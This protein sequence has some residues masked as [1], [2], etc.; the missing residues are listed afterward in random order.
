MTLKRIT[1]EAICNLFPDGETVLI[2]PS[3]RIAQAQLEA[4]QKEYNELKEELEYL[5]E[6]YEVAIEVS[7][8]EHNQLRRDV[9]DEKNRVISELLKER[10]AVVREIFEEI[11]ELDKKLPGYISP[12]IANANPE[13]ATLDV[14]WSDYQALKQKYGVK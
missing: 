13:G 3:E 4:D 14:I 7:D 2:K 11:E 10:E 1:Y 5:Y 6:S 12:E 9:L 8:K